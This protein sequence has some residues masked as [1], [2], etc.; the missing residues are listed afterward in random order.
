MC[1]RA[2]LSVCLP[3]S[4]P[5]RTPALDVGVTSA[6]V[7]MKVGREGV[8]AGVIGLG[9]VGSGR[10]RSSLDRPGIV[11]SGRVVF[12]TVWSGLVGSS[13]VQSGLVW[14]GLVWSGVAWRS[15]VWCGCACICGHSGARARA[16]DTSARQLRKNGRQKSRWVNR[17]SSVYRVAVHDVPSRHVA[18]ASSRPSS[19]ALLRRG[20]ARVDEVVDGD[21]EHAGR[22]GHPHLFRRGENAGHP[23]GSARGPGGGGAHPGRLSPKD[24]RSH[25]RSLRAI[26]ITLE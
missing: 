16:H 19:Y 23:E 6:Y 10:F 22:G 12:G 3:A 2:C 4:S 7:C 1:L 26:S 20:G 14:S 17:A 21:H 24:L 8:R 9:R 13:P 18:S 5:A 11:W 15:M 25:A